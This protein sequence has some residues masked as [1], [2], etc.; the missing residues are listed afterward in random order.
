MTSTGNILVVDDDLLNRLVLST[1]L[2]EQ[3]YDV[4]MAENGRQALEM[5]G[6]QPFDV[7]LLDLVMPELD[8]FQVLEQMKHD[9]AQR[10]IPVIVISALDE[11]ES[12]LR[13]IEMGATDY[14]PKPFDA[15]LLRA[16]LNA[17]LANKRLRDIELEYLEQVNRVMQAAAAVESGTFECDSLNPVAARGDAL[18]QLARV[19]QNMARQVYAREQSLRQQVQE[20]QIEIDEVKK[21]R[22]VAE[23]TET[24]YFRDL[25]ARAQRLR[26]RNGK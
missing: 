3:G 13:C 10:E 24:E 11:M 16:R 6:S 2:Q 8:G 15:A 22:Q 19:F 26:Q 5:L 25:C 17:S 18:G 20:L 14:L 1:N 12:I 7:V 21:A 4:A 23:I 9:S